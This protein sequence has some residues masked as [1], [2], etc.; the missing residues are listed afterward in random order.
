MKV[1][2]RVDASIQI[3]SGHVMRC[4][5]LAQALKENGFDV[6][7]ICR[8]HKGNLIEEIISNG[9]YVYEL[10]LPKVDKT[11]DKLFH[12]N[13]LGVT[14]RQDSIDCINLLQLKVDWMIVDHY[15]IDEDWQ[16]NLRAYY[17]KLMVI[18]DLAD[19]KHQCD[20]L[21]DQ[22][23]GR[24]ESDYKQ[25]TLSFCRMLLG[26]S[27]ALLR[28]NFKKLRPLALKHREK[29]CTIKRIM[30]SMGSI[31]EKNITLIVLNAI[32][33]IRWSNQP[34]I[35]IV[36]TSGA[37]HLNMV[38]N[39]IS[40]FNFIVNVLVDVTN[41]AELMLKSDLAIGSGGSTSW[42][43]CCMAL[44]T[45]LIILAKNQQ[46]V[47][48]SLKQARAV[49]AL[50]KDEDIENGIKQAVIELRDNKKYYLEVSH[51][52]SKVCSGN[53]VREVVKEILSLYSGEKYV[54]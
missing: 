48:E 19:R 25:Y 42:E 13:W 28:P 7:F 2:F 47:G 22:T 36:L 53:G 10:E 44:P 37:P 31:D 23:F 49:I 52:A 29:H 27:Y 24:Q 21:L 14:Q 46:K 34:I 26:S 9:F 40:K 39:S 11:D 51:N 32:S 30:V 12:S 15:S 6:R 18:D 43:R 4:L 3:G 5:A 1:I 17:K 50:S 33:S 54:V 38:K 41:M 8:K 45:V 35:D 16:N 20:I